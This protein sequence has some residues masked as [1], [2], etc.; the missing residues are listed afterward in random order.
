MN[1]QIAI[2]DNELKESLDIFNTGNFLD[3]GEYHNDGN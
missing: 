1:C 3:R 2:I